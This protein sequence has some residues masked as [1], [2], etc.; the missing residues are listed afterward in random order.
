MKYFLLGEFKKLTG[1]NDGAARNLPFLEKKYN[2]KRTRRI[3]TEKDVEEVLKRKP[4]NFKKELKQLKEFQNYYFDNEGNAY[5]NRY[6]Y[7]LEMA[8]DKNT[9]GYYYIRCFNKGKSKRFRLHRIIAMLFIPLVDGKN[10]VNHKDGNKLNN[11]YL[12]LEWT[13]IKENSQHFFDLG[14]SKNKKGFDDSQSIQ[15]N[16]LDENKKFIKTCGSITEAAKELGISPSTISKRLKTTQKKPYKK[17]YFFE[18]NVVQR[19][20]KPQI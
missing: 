13:T 17:K 5:Y 11:N 15:V 10:I 4:E 18:K 12:N 7:L 9:S 1:L 6:G 8:K 2:E 3:F 19:L 14:L 20:S 16:I